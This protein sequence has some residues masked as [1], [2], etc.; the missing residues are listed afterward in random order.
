MAIVHHFTHNH[1]PTRTPLDKVRPIALDVRPI[2]VVT[3]LIGLN[4]GRSN[5][6]TVT[7]PHTTS[8]PFSTLQSPS[9]TIPF[10][11]T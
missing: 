5:A 1:A 2:P 10:N 7:P 3:V 9:L 8:A 4:I 11:H 6:Y